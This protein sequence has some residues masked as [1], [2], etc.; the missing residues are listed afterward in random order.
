[1]TAEQIQHVTELIET[2]KKEG[3]IRHK[4]YDSESDC[5]CAV[6]HAF[7]LAG[8]ESFLQNLKETGRNN[9]VFSQLLH[10][11]EYITEHGTSMHALKSYYGLNYVDFQQLQWIN[12]HN[13]DKIERIE[14]LVAYL[15]DILRQKAEA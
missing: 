9:C 8:Q 7:R 3:T 1:M 6:G 10:I 11:P 5:Y 14:E 15:E 4:Y 12:D 13:A 2:I